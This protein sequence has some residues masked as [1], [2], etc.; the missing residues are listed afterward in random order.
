MFTFVLLETF[1]LLE[2]FMSKTHGMTK[3][4][5]YRI[6]A[7]MKTRC[8]NK[9]E[10]SYKYY[11]GRGIKASDKWKSFE[12]FFADMGECPDGLT[13]DRIDNSKSYSPDNCRWA[14]MK[15]Q[16]N[17]KSNNNW[18]EYDGRKKTLSQWSEE[19]EVSH[20]T[21]LQ[22]L[23]RNWTVGQALGFKKKVRGVCRPPRMLTYKGVTKRLTQWAEDL[24]VHRK[25]LQM[26]LDVYGLKVD[27]AIEY[28]RYRKRMI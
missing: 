4:R 17:N 20:I 7:G 25:T 19:T 21:I 12:S 16:A 13:L 5:T 14:T 8:S 15:Q 28:K 1:N 9:N 18:I 10:T 6:W 2:A 11:G 26:R 23:D 22:R 24:G 27:E 3:T